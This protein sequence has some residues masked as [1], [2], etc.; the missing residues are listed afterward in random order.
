MSNPGI[1]NMYEVYKN[2]YSAL[3]VRDIDKI[4]NVPEPPMPKD[5]A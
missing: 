5:P 4:L 2:M 3:G 1:H